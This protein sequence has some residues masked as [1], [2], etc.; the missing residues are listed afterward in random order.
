M[1]AELP[2][3]R[4]SVL[5]ARR[6]RLLLDLPVQDCG[7][8]SSVSYRAGCFRR[9]RR[10]QRGFKFSPGGDKLPPDPIFYNSMM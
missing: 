9:L 2:V 6:C 4:S 7:I 5:G 10:Q 3:V 1:A 8:I